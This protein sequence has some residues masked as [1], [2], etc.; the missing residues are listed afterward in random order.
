MGR[1]PD[2]PCPQDR[3]RG[4]KTGAL[5]SARARSQSDGT[6]G[7]RLI[8]K[9]ADT[10]DQVAQVAQPLGFQLVSD[11]EQIARLMRADGWEVRFTSTGATYEIE[12]CKAAG[13]QSQHLP[14]N[15]LMQAFAPRIGKEWSKPTLPNQLWFL[16]SFTDQICTAAE[17]VSAKIAAK[18]AAA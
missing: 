4:G 10:L 7:P 11:G 12:L 9:H 2:G 13:G 14:L 3:N 18:A 5:G 16:K 1:V 15:E 6:K 17:T 8:A